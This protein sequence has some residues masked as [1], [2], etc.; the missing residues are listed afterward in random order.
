MELFREVLAQL[1]SEGAARPDPGLEARIERAIEMRCC[2]A[3]E[4]IKAV[5]CDDSLSDP[6]CFEKI[7]RIL[8]ALEEAGVSGGARHDWGK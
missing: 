8:C 6:E 3:L 2:K 7:E 5:V 4:K 1:I